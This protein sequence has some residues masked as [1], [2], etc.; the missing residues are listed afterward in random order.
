MLFTYLFIVPVTTNVVS[1]NS[2]HGKMHLIQHYG[3]KFVTG[4]SIQHIV[5]IRYC[6]GR[7]TVTYR[8][9]VF[10]I[11][12]TETA[13]LSGTNEFPQN[14]EIR[15]TISPTTT[16]CNVRYFK[17][18]LYTRTRTNK[19]YQFEKFDRHGR[20]RM[21]VGFTTTYAISAYHH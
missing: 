6:S 10:T 20:D 18:Y 2:A 12:R 8:V 5:H 19:R 7:L 14:G 4:T 3:T 9:H 17:L 21:V 13:Y 15:S 1:S 11:S 16:R